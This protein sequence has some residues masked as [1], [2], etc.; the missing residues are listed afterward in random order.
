MH[1]ITKF[2]PLFKGKI[3][4]LVEL[5]Q[6]GNIRRVCLDDGKVMGSED[7]DNIVG[8]MAGGGTGLYS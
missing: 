6:K 2:S 8:K 7:V 4:N 5:G 1:L 3:N